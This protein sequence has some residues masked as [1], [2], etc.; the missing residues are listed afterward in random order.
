[1]SASLNDSIFE[2]SDDPI[3]SGRF[4]R[5]RRRG[6]AAVDV[7]P[8]LGWEAQPSEVSN[9]HSEDDTRKPF[10][11]HN[12]ALSFLR[13]TGVRRGLGGEEVRRGLGGEGVRRG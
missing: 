12:A 2:T 6:G 9:L 11:T 4:C 10:E 3:M 7:F 5:L 13:T 1:M 8:S